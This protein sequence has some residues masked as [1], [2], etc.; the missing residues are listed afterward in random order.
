VKPTSC[1]LSTLVLSVV[2]LSAVCLC[3]C[4]PNI[5]TS[6]KLS[7]TASAVIPISAPIQIFLTRQDAG[8]LKLQPVNR[9]QIGQNR[10]ESAVK[11]LLDGPNDEEKSDGLGSE[12]PK[13]TVLIG[14]TTKD[15]NWEL[16]MSRRFAGGGGT[17]SIE[18]RLA[19]LTQTVK[20]NCQGKKVYLDVEG[21]R[22]TLA[23][24]EGIEV[25]QP[26]N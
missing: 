2:S 13:G 3:A 9:K 25:K 6:H 12:I 10:L 8:E 4:T 16:N 1:K 11:Q 20:A 24:G 26:L 15:G 18:T 17:T 7:A 21:E 19:Q 14:L 5:E 23:G 22:L